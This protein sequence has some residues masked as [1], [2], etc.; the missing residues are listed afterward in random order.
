MS[1]SPQRHG[2]LRDRR[3]FLCGLPE[4]RVSVVNSRGL[5]RLVQVGPDL[6]A[7]ERAIVDVELV[8]AGA[9]PVAVIRGQDL[10]RM[11]VGTGVVP[12]DRHP[13]R[14]RRIGLAGELAVEVDLEALLLR[15]PQDRGVAPV[16]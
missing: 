6:V 13:L 15:A 8:A 3:E 1:D 5:P 11:A 9:A 2:E 16:V 7:A 12:R 14:L 10:E 4:L